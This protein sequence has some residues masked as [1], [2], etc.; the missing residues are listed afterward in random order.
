M[1]PA[2]EQKFQHQPIRCFARQG[3]EESHFLCTTII[4]KVFEDLGMT[5]KEDV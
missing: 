1:L 3:W 4:S 5:K 2:N